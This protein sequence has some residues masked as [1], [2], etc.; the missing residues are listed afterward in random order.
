[1]EMKRRWKSRWK[2]EHSPSLAVENSWKSNRF[3]RQPC[4][5]G[6]EIRFPRTRARRASDRPMCAIRAARGLPCRLQPAHGTNHSPYPYRRRKT[7][8]SPH[9]AVPKPSPH[10]AQRTPDAPG[11]PTLGA[12]AA[13]A[14]VIPIGKNNLP[15]L[16]AMRN[17]H[18]F[19]STLAFS[20]SVVEN[21]RFLPQKRG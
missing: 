20:P 9:A 16:P 21:D 6:A 12:I 5:P 14:P 13:K 4:L 2:K 3:P 1:M 11:S 7:A 8:P 10:P 15:T 19:R 17:I 18:F